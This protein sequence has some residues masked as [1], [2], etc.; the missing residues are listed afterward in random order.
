MAR[1]DMT[2]KLD[3]APLNKI[4]TV[5]CFAMDCANNTA[6]R[7]HGESYGMCDYKH[8]CMDENGRCRGYRKKE[9]GSQDGQEG[10]IG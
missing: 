1:A 2:L 4:V 8:I 6:N 7:S 3:T 5:R 9:Q 10:S